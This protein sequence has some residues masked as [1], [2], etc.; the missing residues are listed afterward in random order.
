[1]TLDLSEIYQQYVAYYSEFRNGFDQLAFLRSSRR[2]RA[3]LMTY[4]EF[5]AIWI[6]WCDQ[7]QE[8]Y[9]LE[10]FEKGYAFHAMIVED[11][12]KAIFTG[13]AMQPNPRVSSDAA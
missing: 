3:S 1:M 12:I 2:L 6:Q 8:K 10:R 5:S 9:W 4:E 7:G 11:A 13:N